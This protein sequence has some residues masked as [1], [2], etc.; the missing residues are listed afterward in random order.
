MSQTKVV[1]IARVNVR[2]EEV[3]SK[4]LNDLSDEGN[5][6]IEDRRDGVVVRASLRSW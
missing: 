5:N 4:I 6:D 3:L 2:S 1:K